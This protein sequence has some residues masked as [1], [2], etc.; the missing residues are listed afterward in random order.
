MDLQ[1]KSNAQGTKPKTPGQGGVSN[2]NQN[3]SQNFKQNKGN[4]SSGNQPKQNGNN[5][6][7]N[8]AKGSSSD[9][10]NKNLDKPRDMSKIQCY[11]CL[12]F[13]HFRNKCPQPAKKSDVNFISKL[14]R[15]PADILAPR[16]LYW[17]IEGKSNVPMLRDSAATDD[18]VATE[19]V[20]PEQFTSEYAYCSNAI[21]KQV[22]ALPVAVITITT[23]YGPLELEAL[24]SDAMPDYAKILLGSETL[25][26]LKSLGLPEVE[27]ESSIN[28]ITRSQTRKLEKEKSMTC[29][30][31][32]QLV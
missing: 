25:F 3:S 13:G 24:V 23:P 9:N 19:L 32:L 12:D 11:N 10:V 18:M 17:E 22:T 16:I 5:N 4:G 14:N 2:S 29:T 1:A 31:D 21:T 28:A 27:C 26:K 7:T 30:P 20:K 15:S 8:K 6:Q